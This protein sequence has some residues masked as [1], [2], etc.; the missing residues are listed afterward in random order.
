M[1]NSE[2][3]LLNGIEYLDTDLNILRILSVFTHISSKQGKANTNYKL[4][5]INNLRYIKCH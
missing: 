3:I 1:D 4:A 2:S 5:I